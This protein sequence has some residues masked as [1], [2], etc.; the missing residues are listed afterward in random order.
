MK[1]EKKDW[2]KP[3][4][5]IQEESIKRGPHM[6]VFRFVHAADKKEK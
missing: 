4:P 2:T 3:I 5:Y 1:K 6:Y